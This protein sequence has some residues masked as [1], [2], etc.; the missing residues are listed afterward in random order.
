ML[1]CPE[2]EQRANFPI[3]DVLLHRCC[4]CPYTAANASSGAQAR[5]SPH[6]AALP[7]HFASPSETKT[8][9]SCSAFLGSRLRLSESNTLRPWVFDAST[10][11]P[12][13]FSRLLLR[14]QSPCPCHLGHA[15]LKYCLSS[16]WHIC[17]SLWP[18]DSSS[19]VL[20][21]RHV[22]DLPLDGPGLQVYELPN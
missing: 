20:T 9:S 19:A 5:V 3:D 17:C 14:L 7:R 2:R 8:Y 21:R 22:S 10:S 18:I 11:S 16:D 1:S 15:F 13:Y 6:V 4:R 12:G